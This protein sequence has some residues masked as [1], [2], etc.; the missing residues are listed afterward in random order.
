[1]K[2][3]KRST[4]LW[5]VTGAILGLCTLGTA[6]YGMHSSPVLA[7]DTTAVV[8]AAEQ[9]LNCAHSGDYEALSHMLYGAPNLGAAPEQAE[10]AE[11]AIWQA[12]LDSIDYQIDGACYAVEDALALDVDIQ[13]LD[14]SAV[15][16]SMKEIVPDLLLDGVKNAEDPNTV[17]QTDGSYQEDFAAEVL[18]TAAKQ[19]LKQKQPIK[20]QK[21]TLHFAHADGQWQ[22]V[23]DQ[24]LQ[25]FLSGY[26]TQ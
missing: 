9:T 24:A 11:S 5:A 13:C 8:E 20:E 12:Y 23:P 3:R 14:I 16:A 19:V 2:T 6:V 21:L 1:M 10:T 18:Y 26:V 7:L 25:Q 17:Y 22:V 15:T 4:T